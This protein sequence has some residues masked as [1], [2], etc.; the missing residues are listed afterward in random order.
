MF[1]EEKIVSGFD[2]LYEQYNFE[3]LKQIVPF[4][5]TKAREIL[6][7]KSE[8]YLALM[9]YTPSKSSGG[10]RWQAMRQ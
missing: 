3:K 8:K 4:L 2:S 10:R 5:P 7:M 9:S 1:S 6:Q